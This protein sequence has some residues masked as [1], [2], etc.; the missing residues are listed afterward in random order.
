MDITVPPEIEELA[1][2][3]REFVGDVVI[4]VEEQ[5]GGSVHAA[6][7]ELRRSLQQ[8]AGQA[9]LLAPHVPTEWGG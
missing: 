9:G 3:T 7:E 5:V 4:P 6:P 2:R 1:R 8:Q